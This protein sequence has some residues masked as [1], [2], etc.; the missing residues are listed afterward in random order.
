MVSRTFLT[1]FLWL[2]L[3]EAEATHQAGSLS[4]FLGTLS[5]AK[6]SARA[7]DRPLLVYLYR[8]YAKDHLRMKVAT[9]GNQSVKR[10]LNDHYT[11][12]FLPMDSLRQPKGLDYRLA[13][14]P[15]TL[16]YHPQGNLMGS[17][18]GY[19]SAGTLQQS[20]ARHEARVHPP[21]MTYL[22]VRYAPKDSLYL[23]LSPSPSAQID[24]QVR[25]LETYSLKQI[26]VEGASPTRLGLLAGSYEDFSQLE[27]ALKRMERLWPGQVFVYAETQAQQ[28]AT[29][30]L[31]LGAFTDQS[32]ALRYAD[33]MSRYASVE[34]DLLD[35]TALLR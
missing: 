19:I 11:V 24:L 6:D 33:A 32:L 8:P 14:L 9:W 16:V 18:E 20:L 26:D 25:G 3:I 12:Y 30:K 31:V 7:A 34:T 13:K 35:L 17:L 4:F 15:T 1:L 23:S 2:F 27:R 5:A 28:T 22:P 21:A 29:Y 10:Y